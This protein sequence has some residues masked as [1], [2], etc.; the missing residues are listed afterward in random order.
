MD[1]PIVVNTYF[2]KI[3]AEIA[4]GLLS[5][6]GIESIISADDLS[7]LRSHLAMCNVKLLV[8]EK[9]LKL[10]QEI[11]NTD[12]EKICDSSELEESEATLEGE[13]IYAVKANAIEPVSILLETGANPYAKDTVGKTALDYAQECNNHE[14]IDLL[15]RYKKNRVG[16]KVKK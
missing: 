14:M 13:L 10:A 12:N 1:N 2:D 3:K 5:E 8:E 15:Q 6:N 4:Q 9:D 16:K 7:G 11:L